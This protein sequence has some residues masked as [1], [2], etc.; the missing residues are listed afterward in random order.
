MKF[1]QYCRGTENLTLDHK[2]PRSQGGKNTVSNIQCLCKSCNMM[3]S[4]MS[5]REV[6]SLW[7]WFLDVQKLR[8]DNG[9]KPLF[10][11]K[12]YYLMDNV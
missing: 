9:K 3:K 10:K 7:R 4:G 2:V 5:D 8:I 11:E 12:F 6:K 1:C